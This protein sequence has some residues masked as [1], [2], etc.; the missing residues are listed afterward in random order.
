MTLALQDLTSR[1][2]EEVA[3]S[4][5]IEVTQQRIDQFATATDDRQWIHI[6]AVRATTESPYRPTIAHGFLTLSLVSVMLR[7][8]VRIDV[9]MAINY[10]LN[11]VRFMAPVPAGSK[12]RG[13][14]KRVDV[15]E[16]DAKTLLVTWGVTGEIEGG[17]KPVLIAETLSRRSA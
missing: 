7:T 11:R 6:D 4:D 1:V 14:Y 16:V 17:E 3:V 8:A 13:R 2:G 10:G 12:I 15:K 9:R 5:W